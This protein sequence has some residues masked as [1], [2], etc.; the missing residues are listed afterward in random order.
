MV[1]EKEGK[2]RSL[3]PLLSLTTGSYHLALLGFSV[4]EATKRQLNSGHIPTA[5]NDTSANAPHE[6]N[7]EFPEALRTESF[8]APR[9]HSGL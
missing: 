2:A 8:L 6:V 4:E 5:S 7:S 9:L 3:L 1:G